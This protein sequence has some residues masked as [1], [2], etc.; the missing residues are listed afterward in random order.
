MDEF[1]NNLKRTLQNEILLPMDHLDTDFRYQISYDAIIEIGRN[2][3]S[4][5]RWKTLTLRIEDAGYMYFPFPGVL[6]I[7]GL[8][9]DDEID[10]AWGRMEQDYV[11]KGSF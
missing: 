4:F 3:L 11:E 5:N 6:A 7:E 8:N 9:L 10:S 2:T 1:A